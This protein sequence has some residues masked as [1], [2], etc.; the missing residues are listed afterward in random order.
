MTRCITIVAAC[1]LFAAAGCEQRHSPVLTGR[2]TDA[3]TG[4]PVADARIARAS[5]PE[6][7][8]RSGRDGYY[9]M[10]DVLLPDTFAV[11]CGGYQKKMMVVVGG[12]GEESRVLRNIRIDPNPDTA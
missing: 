6:S 10:E 3:N 1:A 2:V 5:D 9:V 12:R 11:T 4:E 7:F 8:A